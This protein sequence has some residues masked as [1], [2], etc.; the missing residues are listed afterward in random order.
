VVDVSGG[1][2]DV[3]VASGDEGGDGSSHHG[4]VIRVDGTK[5]QDR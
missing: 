1:G 2:D 3:H 4:V 5:V